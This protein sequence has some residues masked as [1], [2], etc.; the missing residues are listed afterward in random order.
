MAARVTSCDNKGLMVVLCLCYL[1]NRVLLSL[2]C[3]LSSCF[4]AKLPKSDSLQLAMWN[5]PQMLIIYTFIAF[6]IFIRFC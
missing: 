3:I 2:I 5:W 1:L 6:V 4:Y